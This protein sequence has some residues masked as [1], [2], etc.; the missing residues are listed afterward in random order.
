MPLTAQV[1]KG[2]VETR[3]QYAVRRVW[4]AADLYSQEHVLPQELQLMMRANVYSLKGNSEVK[5]AVEG[6]VDALRSNLHITM[7]DERHRRSG[8]GT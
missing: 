8:T 7:K 5:C 6:A 1:L 4:W 2:V 3:E